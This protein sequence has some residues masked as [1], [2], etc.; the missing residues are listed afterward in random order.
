MLKCNFLF[1]VI[2]LSAASANGQNYFIPNQWWVQKP[3][4][5]PAA[6][7]ISDKLDVAIGTRLGGFTNKYTGSYTFGAVNAKI[8]AINSGVGFSYFNENPE[9]LGKTNEQFVMRQRFAFT[10][11]YQF[12]F[13]NSHVLAL[14]TSVDFIR[15]SWNINWLP[16]GGGID[17]GLPPPSGIG[18][19]INL[20]FGAMYQAENWHVG[21]SAVPSATLVDAENLTNQ[22][23]TFYL[24]A[25]YLSRFNGTFALEAAGLGGLDIDNWYTLNYNLKLWLVDAYYTGVGFSVSRNT[26]DSVDLL[27]G[28]TLF[29]QLKIHYA[30]AF[31]LSDFSSMTNQHVISLQFALAD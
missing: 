27:F 24:S 19:D 13:K 10:Y 23:T 21:L 31:T 6:S 18:T 20:G 17:P 14:G 7:G 22:A 26:Y 9:Y 4:F 16:P 30:Y 12:A 25:S 28:L 29:K 2:L 11:N 3:L 8:S 1:F 15:T 5:N